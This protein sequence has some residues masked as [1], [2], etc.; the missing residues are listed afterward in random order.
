MKAEF[1][2]AGLVCTDSSIDDERVSVSS[3]GKRIWN[4]GAVIEHEEAYKLVRLGVAVPA[5]EECAARAKMSQERI[6]KALHAADR[7]AAGI[8]PEDYE[9]FDSGRILGYNPD[10]SYI[11][12]PNAPEAQSGD[13][14]EGGVYIP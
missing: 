6:E 11:T 4:V 3:D 1:V 2:K 10:G 5:D 9:L 8:H 13:Y 7:V 14:T 12:G